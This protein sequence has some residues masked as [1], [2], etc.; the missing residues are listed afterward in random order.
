MVVTD[1]M[2]GDQSSEETLEEMTVRGGGWKDEEHL[3]ALLSIS[4]TVDPF[5]RSLVDAKV[6]GLH[7]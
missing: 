5:V 2:I 3:G 4:F 1:N 7:G 6:T